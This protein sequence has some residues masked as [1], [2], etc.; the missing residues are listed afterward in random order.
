ML[1]LGIT[2]LAGRDYVAFSAFTAADDRN[3]VVHSEI[4]WWESLSAIITD[5]IGALPLP[6]LTGTQL[7][8]PLPLA[9]DLFFTDGYYE[10][11]RL[12]ASP[13]SEPENYFNQRFSDL[14]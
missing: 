3:Q 11:G 2:L 7:P 4:F 14:R 5:P 6:P 10:R 9:P 13:Y 12:H 8:G 1:F